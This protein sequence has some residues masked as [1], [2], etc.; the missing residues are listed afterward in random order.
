MGKNT[1]GK[2]HN[3]VKY[4]KKRR[5]KI[6]GGEKTEGLTEHVKCIH[7][8]KTYTRVKSVTLE[9]KSSAND[10]KNYRKKSACR[11]F[12]QNSIINFRIVRNCFAQKEENFG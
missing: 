9:I 12:I 7:E 4:T 1:R 2:K 10:K 5:V 11:L 8:V 6:P 3:G